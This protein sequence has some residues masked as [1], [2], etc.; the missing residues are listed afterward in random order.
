MKVIEHI[1]NA[2]KTLFSLELLPPLKGKDVSTIYDIIDPLIEFEPK[3]IN[4]TSHRDEVVY[5]DMGN[6]LMKK[7]VVRKRPGTVPVSAAIWNKYKI[8]VVPHIIC[9]GFN[10]TETEY[11]LIDLNFLGLDNLLLLRGDP[12]KSERIFKAEENGHLHSLDLIGQ[13]NDLNKGIYLDKHIENSVNMNFS[14]GVA[15]YP[16]K[17]SE[18]PNMEAD[19]YYL[20]KKVE[21]GAE[22]IVTQ[23]FF[24]NQ[25]YY[26]FVDICRNNGINIPIIPGIKPLV[27]KNQ[28]SVLSQIFKI[29]IP[30]E[31]AKDVR[32]C[33]TDKEANELGIEWSI[34]QCKDLI[35]N[36]VPVL[37]F[38]TMGAGKSVKRIAK[39]IF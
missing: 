30:E 15:G 18:A 21:K 29:D 27:L 6:G 35:K 32:K 9:S 23:M 36:N 14:F 39:E 33:K 26:D 22:Y 24:D 11:A 28:I 25:K 5:K 31:F 13:V 3:F 16:E 2:K 1:K 10:K 20:K 4:V 38:Y 37:H 8:T 17:H 19:I 34:K 7:Q 12:L